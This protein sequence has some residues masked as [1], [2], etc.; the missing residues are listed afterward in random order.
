MYV[1][2]IGQCSLDYLFEVDTYPPPDTKKEFLTL[3]EESGGPVAT[4]LVALSRLGIP[5]R[6]NGITGDDDAGKKIRASLEKENI[7]VSGLFKR[8]NATSQIAFI[9]IEKGSA[10]RTIFWKRPSGK[11]LRKKELPNDLFAHTRF[12]LLDGLMHEV[13]LYAAGRARELNIPVMLDAGRARPGMIEIAR[14]CDYVV[15]S[16]EFARDLEWKLTEQGL[17]IQ[18]MLL[19]VKILTVTLGHHG[20]VTVSGDGFIRM[21]AF[22]V[23]AVDTT[24]AGDVFHGGYLYGL[25]QGWEL[26][27]VL[28]FASALAALKC[29]KV[30]GRAGIAKLAEVRDFL[31]ATGHQF[32]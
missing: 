15:A 6:F 1:S 8:R 30:G 26:T 29:R 4:A 19:G 32:L 25:L 10:R 5:C 3:H 28:L 7:D 23:D 16:E 20:S 27:N 17:S 22:T 9:A 24:G 13:S 14:S 31:S 12:L 2:G 11:A 21:P 18:R